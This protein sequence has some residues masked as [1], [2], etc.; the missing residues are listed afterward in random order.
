MKRFSTILLCLGACAA[1]ATLSS[2][3]FAAGGSSA[4]VPEAPHLT[5]EQT[6]VNEYN[7]GLR[8]REKAEENDAKAGTQ[9]NAKKRAK[10]EAKRDALFEKAAKRF[11]AAIKAKHDF[12]QAHGSLGYA[13]R[14]LGRYDESMQAYDTALGINPNYPAAIEYR[15]EALLGLDRVPEALKAY[16]R[17]AVISAEHAA[18][19]LAAVKTW[20]GDEAN[21]EAATASDVAAWVAHREEVSSTTASG[22]AGGSRSWR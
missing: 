11:E 15:A 6:A 21:A 2:P 5:P 19:L 12:A 9:S 20:A 4:P 8:Y 3:L 1:L 17:L 7:S 10:L 18:E 16:E 13:L 22:A 14:R